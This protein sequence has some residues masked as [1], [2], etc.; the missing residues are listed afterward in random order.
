MQAARQRDNNVREKQ[1]KL[2]AEHEA[3]IAE[4]TRKEAA[5]QARRDLVNAARQQRI[6]DGAVA[7]S[8]DDLQEMFAGPG[9]FGLVAGE[10][11]RCR[12]MF[13]RVKARYPDGAAVGKDK[14]CDW[15]KGDN[16]TELGKGGKAKVFEKLC[17]YLELRDRP[18]FW[19]AQRDRSVDA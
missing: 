15:Q 4:A 6:D 18:W 16:K 2:A 14:S 19:G 11:A 10:T 3:V 9:R 8:I 13:E 17:A 12:N 7:L 5:A 1:Y